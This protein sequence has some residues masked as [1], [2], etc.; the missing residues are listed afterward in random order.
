MQ[1]LM[2]VFDENEKHIGIRFAQDNYAEFERDR[3][4]TKIEL[5]MTTLLMM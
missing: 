4:V 1:H 5:G 3:T 2:F